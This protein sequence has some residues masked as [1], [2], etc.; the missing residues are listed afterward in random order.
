MWYMR[1]QLS[2]HE[3]IDRTRERQNLSFSLVY[4][5]SFLSVDCTYSLEIYSYAT[6]EFERLIQLS[7]YVYAVGSLVI[8]FL[9]FRSVYIQCFT[10]H[11]LLCLSIIKT[12][13]TRYVCV[14]EVSF[15]FLFLLS[16]YKTNLYFSIYFGH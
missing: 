12:S 7:D 4:W 16:F 14:C 8:I 6:T 9:L 15:F 5:C 2:M 3:L 1:V 10:R 11:F 13:M